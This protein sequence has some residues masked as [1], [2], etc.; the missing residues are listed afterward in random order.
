M[1]MAHQCALGSSEGCPTDGPSFDRRLE[2]TPP[3][4]PHLL[5]HGEALD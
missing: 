2:E 1:G 3:L 4:A 5:K